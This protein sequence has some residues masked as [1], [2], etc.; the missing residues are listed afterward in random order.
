[1]A[2]GILA[3][4]T[5]IMA[6]AIK[7]I[8]VEHGLD[9]REFVL[10]CYGGGG[11]L[12]ASALARELSIPTVVIPPEPGNFSAVGMLLADARLDLSKTFTGVLNDATVASLKD[13]FA[14][15]EAEARAALVRDFGAGDV[16]FERHA[17]MR[18]AG[19]R[20]NIKVPISGLDDPAGIR[21]GLRPR[22]QAPL[23]PRRRHA[24]RPSS[25]RCISRPSRGCAGRSSRI[26]RARRSKRRSAATRPV[27]FGEAGGT[28]D[29][30]G[31]R[32]HRARAGLQGRG[33]G[34]DRGIWIDHAD[35]ARR[36]L[37]GRHAGRN[38]HRTAAAS[39]PIMMQEASHRT[40]RCR[41]RSDHARGD[42][43]RPRLDHQPDRRQ[44]Q[45]HGVQPLHLRVQRFRGRPRRRRRPAGRAMHRRHAAVRRRLGRHGGA[46]RACDLRPRA[47]APRR[48]RALQSRRR[49]GPA[50][51]QHGDVHADLC[52]AATAPR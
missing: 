14:E 17:E 48:R 42:P 44:H 9:P 21:A 4:A 51:Q 5:V 8:S 3:L 22:L 36:P 24:P 34:L 15:M 19:Q 50:S 46:R 38:P 29:G 41:H 45:A 30:A 6:G 2:D 18:Y 23:R 43:P 10:F 1:M 12:H 16:L 52:R 35:L 37:R 20:H 40:H 7:Q 27:Y 33:P 28:V 47:A 31:L 26:C 32:S 11:P 13:A 49:A 39:E 25:R